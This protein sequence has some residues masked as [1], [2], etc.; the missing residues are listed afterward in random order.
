M[1][2][3]W[4]MIY[5]DGYDWYGTPKQ[6]F[7]YHPLLMFIGLLFLYGNGQYNDQAVV[8]VQN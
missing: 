3:V 5:R 4:M 2:G 6:Q 1:V 8:K 7:S